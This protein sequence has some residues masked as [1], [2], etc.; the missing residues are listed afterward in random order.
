MIY[1]TLGFLSGEISYGVFLFGWDRIIVARF[2][3]RCGEYYQVFHLVTR[4]PSLGLCVLS[5][6][7]HVARMRYQVLA[8][9][10]VLRLSVAKRGLDASLVARMAN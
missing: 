4:S 2:L 10:S 9:P 3:Y 8:S 7:N 5:N 1:D 6:V